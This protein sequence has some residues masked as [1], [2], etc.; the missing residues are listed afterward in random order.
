LYISCFKVGD[1]HQS[2]NHS[3][4]SCYIQWQILDVDEIFLDKNRVEV[5]FWKYVSN[6]RPMGNN[7][8]LLPIGKSLG[9]M[10]WCLHNHKIQTTFEEKLIKFRQFY[11][12]G[13]KPPTPQY[14]E[15]M[16]RNFLRCSLTNVILRGQ[17]YNVF[18]N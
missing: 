4:I 18:L 16:S 13:W 15:I 6:E 12:R 2:I 8:I 11:K 9:M 17:L 3:F 5:M 1:K 7:I 10:K 14:K